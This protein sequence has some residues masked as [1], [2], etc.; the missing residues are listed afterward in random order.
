AP[1]RVTTEPLAA[2]LLALHLIAEL[3]LE[4]REALAHLERH[5]AAHLL[6]SANGR[7]LAAYLL[8]LVRPDEMQ[9]VLRD[10]LGRGLAIEILGEP[11]L[12]RV[13]PDRAPDRKANEALDWRGDPQPMLHLLG[14]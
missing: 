1:D 10:L 7:H 14:R 3:L 5:L 4:L 11:T 13:P 12:E 9:V 6:A 2:R 8:T